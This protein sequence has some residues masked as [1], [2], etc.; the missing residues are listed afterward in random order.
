VETSRRIGGARPAG[1][2]ADAGPARELAHRLRHDAGAAFLPA[3][4]HLE[5]TVHHG[6][7]RSDV[8]FAGHAEDMA[9]AMNDEL[10]DQHL[11]G[12][13]RS[14]IGAHVSRLLRLRGTGSGLIAPPL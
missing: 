2:E 1:D 13:S 12:G 9:R 5:G 6:V 7:E 11:G 14:I 8:A 4:R 3:N 10:I